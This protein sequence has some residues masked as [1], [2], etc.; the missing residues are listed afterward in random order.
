MDLDDCEKKKKVLFMHKNGKPRTR[1]VKE[2]PSMM[3]D[4]ILAEQR[5]QKRK[6]R[7]PKPKPKPKEK[8][9][10]KERMKLELMQSLGGAFDT[11]GNLLGDT[12]EE[13]DAEERRMYMQQG[14]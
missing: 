14:E 3:T 1:M 7:P 13:E 2:I 6:K 11:A 10:K 5:E 9:G 4:L 8:M 12:D